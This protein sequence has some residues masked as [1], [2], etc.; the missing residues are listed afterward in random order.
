MEVSSVK[1]LLS[2]WW[3]RPHCKK[4]SQK[5]IFFNYK[6]FSTYLGKEITHFL[7]HLV[8]PLA[9]IHLYESGSPD[10]DARKENGL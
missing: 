8:Q 9:R 7:H 2:T 3:I 10:L 5:C 4:K 1:A 6:Y